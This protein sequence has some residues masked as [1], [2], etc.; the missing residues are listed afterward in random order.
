MMIAVHVASLCVFYGIVTGREKINLVILSW[1]RSDI[2][3]E[4]SSRSHVCEVGNC[5]L[6]IVEKNQ[7]LSRLKTCQD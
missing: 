6:D 4:F 5:H 2:I 7:N 3:F 1:N